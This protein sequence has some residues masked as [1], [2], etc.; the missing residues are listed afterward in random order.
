M[1][2]YFNTA[3]LVIISIFKTPYYYKKGSIKR[4]YQHT[5]C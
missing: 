2:I 1:R 3:K 5:Q 4:I